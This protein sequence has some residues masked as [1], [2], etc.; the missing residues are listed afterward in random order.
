MAAMAATVVL[1]D[2][3]DT[4]ATVDM[5]AMV[6]MA[7]TADTEGTAT[8]YLPTC[9]SSRLHP[10]SLVLPDS[11]TLVLELFGIIRSYLCCTSI[12]LQMYS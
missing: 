6:D 1:A 2:M 5:E 8:I 4:A 12:P 11:S 9:L 3:V 7:D 10:L